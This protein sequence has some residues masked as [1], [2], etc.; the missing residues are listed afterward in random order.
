MF[1]Y[2]MCA[3]IVLKVNI[4][5]NYYVFVFYFIPFIQQEQKQKPIYLWF[6]CDYPHNSPLMGHL[7]SSCAVNSC[8][9]NPS[10]LHLWNNSMCEFHTEGRD[11][12]P[13]LIPFKLHTMPTD[14]HSTLE[15]IKPINRTI[16][17]PN[18]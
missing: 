17:S 10:K 5:I 1:S 16:L 12:W 14:E 18:I 8:T 7:R 2:F 11:H 6:A 4:N 15:W 13:C 9:S 3:Y